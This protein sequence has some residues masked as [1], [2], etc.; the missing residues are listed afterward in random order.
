MVE[1]FAVEGKDSPA[2]KFMRKTFPLTY[3]NFLRILE[4]KEISAWI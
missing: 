4:G 2:G 3:K 1:L